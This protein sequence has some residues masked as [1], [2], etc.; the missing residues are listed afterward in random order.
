MMEFEVFKEPGNIKV[1]HHEELIAEFKDEF[2]YEIF[3]DGVHDRGDIEIWLPE[4][5]RYE[6]L[7]DR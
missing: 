4:E 1:M 5:A 3:L 6:D 7:H 2:A